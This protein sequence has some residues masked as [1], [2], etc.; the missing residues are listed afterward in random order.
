MLVGL[1]LKWAQF[2]NIN[3]NQDVELVKVA[4]NSITL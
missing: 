1:N 4:T 3:K 2:A